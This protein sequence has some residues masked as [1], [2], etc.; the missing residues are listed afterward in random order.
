M[1]LKTQI[2]QTKAYLRS[3]ELDI[4]DE[5]IIEKDSLLPHRL[6]EYTRVAVTAINEVRV[7]MDNGSLWYRRSGCRVGDLLNKAV[8][9]MADPET[10]ELAENVTRFSAA[11]AKFVDTFKLGFDV[12]RARALAAAAEAFDVAMES[13][14]RRPARPGRSQT[15]TAELIAL[16][17]FRPDGDSSSPTKAL[18]V[19]RSREDAS[20]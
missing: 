1:A 18:L 5:F 14:K 17:E 2:E 6:P 3:G 19:D 20:A 8:L 9:L 11:Q 15:G 10:V 7:A 13:M 4:G 12:K 16:N